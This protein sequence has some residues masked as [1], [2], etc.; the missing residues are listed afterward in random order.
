MRYARLDPLD[1]DTAPLRESTVVVVGAGAT[2][3]RMLEQLARTGADLRIVDRD[4]L[5]TANLATSALYTEEQVEER[6]PKAVAAERRLEAVNGKIRI[7]ADVAD[8]THRNADT[9]LSPADIVLDGTD[10]VETRYLINEYCVTHEVPWVHVAALGERG[11]VMP[12]RPGETACFNCVFGDVDSAALATCETGGID[13]AAASTAA[14]LGVRTAAALRDGEPVQ[15]LT[16]FDLGRG[17][18]HDLSVA[19]EAC[20][21]CRGEASPYLDGEKGSST[22]R[23]CGEDQYQVR[24][25]GDVDLERLADELAEQGTVQRNDHLLRFHDGDTRFTV[26]RGGRMLVEAESPEEARSIYARYVGV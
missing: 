26:F 1:L 13:P 20:R 11:A 18:F 4:V 5:E 25:A 23:V 12:V 8:L 3:S 24:G 6:L 17:T 15:G 9:L 19:R 7:E 2:G 14:A 16:R 10:N 21:V 22:A